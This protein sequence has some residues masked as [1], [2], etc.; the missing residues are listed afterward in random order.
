MNEVDKL[1]K[2]AKIG[3]RFRGLKP[4]VVKTIREGNAHYIFGH[5]YLTRNDKLKIVTV[6]GLASVA[7]L[8]LALLPLFIAR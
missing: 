7:C 6:A 3:I 4:E 8:G 2:K 5:E 1:A